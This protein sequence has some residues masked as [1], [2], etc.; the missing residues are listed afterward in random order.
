MLVNGLM[1][2]RTLSGVTKWVV[3]GNIGSIQYK[4]NKR[5]RDR[6]RD[7]ETETDRETQTDRQTD[8]HREILP[9]LG[10]GPA[11][12]RSQAQ[13]LNYSAKPSPAS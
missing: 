8:R 10:F 6:D 7:R 4:Q 5:E 1:V 12:S 2:D 9:A 3:W 11:T 13:G